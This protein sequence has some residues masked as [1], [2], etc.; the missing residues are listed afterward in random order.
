MS[1]PLEVASEQVAAYVARDLERFMATY[2]PTCIIQD[3]IGQTLMEGEATMREVY[4]ALFANSPGLFCRV[5]STMESGPYVV[6]EED[7]G[8][9]NLPGY[10]EA[11][12]AAVVYRVEN[13]QITHVRFLW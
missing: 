2:A 4:G 10:P 6:V 3:G 13:D 12:H 9:M 5:V 7:C 8:G 1:S 11:V